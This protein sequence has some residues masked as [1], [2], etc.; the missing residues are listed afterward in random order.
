MEAR[1]TR[2]P[3]DLVLAM[4]LP[5]KLQDSLLA[6]V[7]MLGVDRLLITN[8]AKVDHSLMGFHLFRNSRKL[9]QNM[10]PGLEQSGETYLPRVS[11]HRRLDRLLEDLARWPDCTS[12]DLRFTSRSST[13]LEPYS[14]L[15]STPHAEAQPESR[16]LLVAHPHSASKQRD[17]AG[18]EW[19]S[20][21]YPTTKSFSQLHW[22]RESKGCA[23]RIVLAIGPERGWQEPDELDLFLEHGFQPV[24]LAPSIGPLRTEL[25]LS[26]LVSRAHEKVSLGE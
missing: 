2:P 14:P 12:E 16:L 24:S 11:L 23:K 13:V 5:R 9:E 26:A 1:A 15:P 7:T 21:M 18:E 19:S 3:V 17:G 8:G 4:P 10:R 22:P 25:A 6:S 20:S